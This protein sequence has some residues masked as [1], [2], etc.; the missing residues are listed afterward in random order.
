MYPGKATLGYRTA[1]PERH[2]PLSWSEI[3]LLVNHVSWQ[4]FGHTLGGG[5]GI[6]HM[7]GG[8]LGM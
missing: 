5:V 7:I 2:R 4:N 3:N 1:K 8:A 6:W